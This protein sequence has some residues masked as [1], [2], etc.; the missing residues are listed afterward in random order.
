MIRRAVERKGCWLNDYLD[1]ISDAK[2]HQVT[3]MLW[4]KAWSS[5]TTAVTFDWKSFEFV[6]AS[7]PHIPVDAGVYAFLIEPVMTSGLPVAYLIYIGQ[8][9]SLRRRFGEY[10][11]EVEKVLGRPK[12]VLL[13]NQYRDHL[14]FACSVLTGTDLDPVEEGLL[15]AY[16]PPANDRL[17]A[18]VSRVMRAF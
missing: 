1:L 8:T 9:S 18:S 11:S 5:Y 10:L 17:P 13:L 16:I 14:Q 3:F 7:Q 2:A 15:A 4:P 6:P 12:I